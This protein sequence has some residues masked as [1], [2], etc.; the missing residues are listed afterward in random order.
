[1]AMAVPL[2]NVIDQRIAQSSLAPVPCG[3]SAV[4]QHRRPG[5]LHR[6]RVAHHQRDRHRPSHRPRK[7]SGHGQQ[8]HCR[9]QRV[10]SGAVPA[11]ARGPGLVRRSPMRP[12]TWTGLTWV[13]AP[14]ARAGDRSTRSATGSPARRSPCSWPPGTVCPS[15]RR[16]SGSGCTPAACPRPATPSPWSTAQRAASPRPPAPGA[17]PAWSSTSGTPSRPHGQPLHLR[18]RRSGQRR[19]RQLAHRPRQHAQTDGHLH[20]AAPTT[21]SRSPPSERA[22]GLSASLV[23]SIPGILAGKTPR[24]DRSLARRRTR[25]AGSAVAGAGP[26]VALIQSVIVGAFRQ[27]AARVVARRPACPSPSP[28]GASPVSGAAGRPAVRRR[29]SCCRRG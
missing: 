11:R 25:G 23:T 24:G 4:H 22:Q 7:R 12:R 6:Q 14:N 16:W 3:G 21:G 20:H 2:H 28:C 8:D 29:R 18:Q 13:G 17:T 27:A 9:R 15:A 19:L 1:M 5:G 10:Q 26:A